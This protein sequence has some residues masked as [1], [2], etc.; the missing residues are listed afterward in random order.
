L[1]LIVLSVHDEPSVRRAAMKAGADGFVL[2]RAIAT[3]LMST[4]ESLLGDHGG[5]P[6]ANGV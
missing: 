2:K 3:D 6:S 5:A 1:K 4:A